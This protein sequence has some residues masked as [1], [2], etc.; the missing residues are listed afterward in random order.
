MYDNPTG[1][2]GMVGIVGA[3]SKTE[4]DDEYGLL[5]DARGDE[6]RQILEKPRRP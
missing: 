6:R 3:L 4:N 5:E 2:D 1:E